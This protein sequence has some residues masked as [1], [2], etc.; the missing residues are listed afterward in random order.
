MQKAFALVAALGLLAGFAPALV[1]P[2]SADTVIIHRDDHH[3]RPMCH[4]VRDVH[5][6]PRGKTVVVHKVCR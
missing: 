6:G 4:M 1:T 5:F 2:A 3:H